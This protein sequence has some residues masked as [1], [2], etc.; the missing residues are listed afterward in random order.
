VIGESCLDRLACSIGGKTILPLA[1]NTISQMLQNP[2]WKHRFAALMAISAVGE[3]CHDQIS[4]ILNQ[5]VDAII[6]FLADSH[7]RVRYAACNALGQMS[8]DFCPT[9]EETF[10]AKVIPGLLTLLDDYDN[11]RVQAHAGAALVNFFEECPQKIVISYLE[12][13][14]SKIEQVLN[15]KVKEVSIGLN[16]L[17]SLSLL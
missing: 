17:F 2:D 5:I 12:T 7:P 1:I 11:P 10:H 16:I 3:G 15:V 4:P 14:V 8:T 9:F 13:V 6:P